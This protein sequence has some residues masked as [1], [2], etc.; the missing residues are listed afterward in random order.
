M[1]RQ[2]YGI[3]TQAL[4]Q[5]T[6]RN[7]LAASIF[8][9][10]VEVPFTRDRFQFVFIALN[11]ICVNVEDPAC[12]FFPDLVFEIGCTMKSTFAGQLHAD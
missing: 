7:I 1:L 4:H 9:L 8:Y 5:N 2:R 10:P 6:H 11:K 3:A 12:S